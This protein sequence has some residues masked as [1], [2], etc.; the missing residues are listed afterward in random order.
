M[1]P[2]GV[3]PSQG[4]VRLAVDRDRA[5]RC[6]APFAGLLGSDNMSAAPPLPSPPLT[7]EVRALERARDL[8]N[9]RT[10]TDVEFRRAALFLDHLQ[11]SQGKDA[12]HRHRARPL[13]LARVQ[14]ARPPHE[15]LDPDAAGALPDRREAH[16]LPVRRVPDGEG[17]RQQ[18][19][20]PRHLRRRARRAAGIGL[21]LADLLLEEPDAGLGN[22][23]LGRLAACFLDS[24]ATLGCRPTATASATSSASSTQDILDGYQVE[25]ADEWLRFGNPWEI[26]RPGERGAGALRRP[27][28][29]PPWRATAGTACAL[30]RAARRCSACP[31]TRPIAGFGNDTVNTLRLWQ[32]RASERVRPRALQRRRLRARGGGEERLGGHLQ[33]PL[34]ERQLPGRARSC[35]SSSSTSSSPAPSPT[36]SGAT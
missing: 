15:A 27:R 29:A 18:P 19:H 30:G 11:F 4:L 34:P 9:A 31:T 28:G 21:E 36:S 13:L 20:Q 5:G 6:G 1:D 12:A 33:G 32:A 8:P 23:G 17:A 10:A 3:P 26:V 16:L 24:M 25:R 7:A 22:G 35:A 2:S 14:R